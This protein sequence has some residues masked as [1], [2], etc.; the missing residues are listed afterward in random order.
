V[1]PFDHFDVLAIIFGVMF[2]LR[3]LDAKMRDPADQP[4]VPSAEFERWKRAATSAYG[5]GSAVCFLRVVVHF[6]WV[7]YVNRH[8]V[9]WE[10]FRAVGLGTDIIW[11]SGMGLALWRARSAR[12]LRDQLGIA[13]RR[14]APR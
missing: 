8:H 1:Q 13:L 12:K 11:L 10:L 5:I 6:A 7:L 3:K 14:P 2:Q 4:N 9:S